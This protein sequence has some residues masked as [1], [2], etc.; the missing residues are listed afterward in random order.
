MRTPLGVRARALVEL[1]GDEVEWVRAGENAR[2]MRVVNSASSTSSSSLPGCFAET[3]RQCIGGPGIPLGVRGLGRGVVPKLGVWAREGGRVP[4]PSEGNG[5]I[6]GLDDGA[7]DMDEVTGDHGLEE[8]LE[9]RDKL[10]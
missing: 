6:D 9:L 7:V 3:E 10:R 4:G 8:A 5:G 2:C 1:P